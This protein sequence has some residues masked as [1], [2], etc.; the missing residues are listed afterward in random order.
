MY[1]ELICH[2]NPN[3]WLNSI[4]FIMHNV[5][6]TKCVFM[7]HH[8]YSLSICVMLI[9]LCRNQKI[10][11]DLI[12]VV[13]FLYLL[14]WELT[15]NIHSTYCKTGLIIC[16]HL[17]SRKHLYFRVKWFSLD[18]THYIIVKVKRKVKLHCI[19]IT[20][21]HTYVWDMERLSVYIHLSST[22]IVYLTFKPPFI[23]NTHIYETV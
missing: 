10:S 15:L 1:K 11:F 2:K 7:Y 8:I 18:F 23:K 14:D 19:S 9:W 21:L 12:I 17:R 20:I 22:Y 5:N 4:L 3:I 6:P 13:F 16:F